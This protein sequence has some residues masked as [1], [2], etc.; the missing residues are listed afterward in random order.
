MFISANVYAFNI[1]ANPYF[2]FNG[3][4]TSVTYKAKSGIDYANAMPSKY[5]GAGMYFGVDLHEHWAFELGYDQ[6]LSQ[7]Q[8]VNSITGIDTVESRLIS[9]R[10]D[11]I[12]KKTVA[13][14]LKLV[15][16]LGLVNGVNNVSIKANAATVD[17]NFQ[18]GGFS[19]GYEYGVGFWK[20]EPEYYTYRFEYKNRN[21]DYGGIADS[22]RII[23]FG[24][25]VK[26]Y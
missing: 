21:I 11:V 3:F 19:N 15:G 9:M 16:I 2:G 12:F 5:W 7:S 4:Q 14:D 24:V 10:Y 18:Q 20:D 6:T 23:N 26:L 22:S 13:T 17:S 25:N 1:T 8:R